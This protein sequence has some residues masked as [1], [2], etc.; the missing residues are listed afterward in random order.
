VEDDFVWEAPRS[1]AVRAADGKL[2]YTDA[3][4]EGR[5]TMRIDAFSSVVAGSATLAGLAGMGM[6]RCRGGC[7]IAGLSRALEPDAPPVCLTGF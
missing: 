2:V 7:D 3:E 5:L 4:P 1:V 6:V